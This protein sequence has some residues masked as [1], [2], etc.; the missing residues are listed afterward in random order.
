MQGRDTKMLCFQGV[1]N[2]GDRRGRLGS[3]S[4]LRK[5]PGSEEPMRRTGGTRG[6]TRD[7]PEAP[8][9]SSGGQVGL[10]PRSG[11]GR[12]LSPHQALLWQGWQG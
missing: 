6:V 1:H 2:L 8:G 11:V 3:G 10:D 9:G 7:K 4:L 5:A 12:T